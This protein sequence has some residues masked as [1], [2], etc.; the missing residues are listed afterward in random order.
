MNH[1]LRSKVLDGF[2][3][4]HLMA[5]VPLLGLCLFLCLLLFLSFEYVLFLLNLKQLY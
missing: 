2:L 5:L 4:E 1:T 3:D